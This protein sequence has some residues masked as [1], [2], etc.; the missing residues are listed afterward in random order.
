LLAELA[1]QQ[2]AD[3][4]GVAGR[5]GGER[6]AVLEAGRRHKVQHSH[7]VV[8]GTI[9]PVLVWLRDHKGVSLNIEVIRF[10]LELRWIWKLAMQKI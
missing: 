5:E 9:A 1:R 7:V 3:R 2:L 8:I 4:V 6:V 10:A